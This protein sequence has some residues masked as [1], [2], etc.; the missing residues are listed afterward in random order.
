[1]LIL[2]ACGGGGN[3][4]TLATLE[5][6]TTPPT[7]GG[8]ST[9]TSIPEGTY[10]PT[11]VIDG[12]ISG[13]N[14][15][16]DMNYNFQQDNWEPSAY[17]DV[18]GEYYYFDSNDF[19]HIDNYDE[20]CLLQRPRIAE[21]PVGATD[22]IRGVVNEAYELYF[23]PY[24]N[25][26]TSAEGVDAGNVTPFTTFLI[27][28][29]SVMFRNVSITEENACSNESRDY[30]YSFMIKVQDALN[31]LENRFGL[32]TESFYDDFIASGDTEKQAIAERLVDFLQTAYKAMYAIEEEYNISTYS[33]L[34]YDLFNRILNGEEINDISFN[35]ISITRGTTEEI[36]EGE[37][38][39]VHDVYRVMDIYVNSSGQYYDIESGTI[40]EPT[41]D[42]L[43]IYGKFHVFS[44]INDV[45]LTIGKAKLIPNPF[46]DITEKRML[47]ENQHANIL[48][49]TV[50]GISDLNA[51]FGQSL[52]SNIKH[53]NAFQITSFCSGPWQLSCWAELVKT[54]E[55]ETELFNQ[56]SH[57]IEI[58]DQYESLCI[59]AN[60]RHALTANFLIKEI[61]NE[62]K[63]TLIYISPVIFPFDLSEFEFLDFSYEE[64]Q[65][66]NDL[67]E[68]N[69]LNRQ[70]M[71]L[72]ASTNEFD[73]RVNEKHVFMITNKLEN[74]VDMFVNY[75]VEGHE[76]YI[77]TEMIL[78]IEN[79]C[80]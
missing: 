64:I 25:F 46:D 67:I 39:L 60:S 21:V 78:K 30:A 9:S 49:S 14:V 8:G 72:I 41:M 45:S 22:S 19:T 2:S 24:R 6:Q 23:V 53:D 56:L 44:I 69:Y 80:N 13:A 73:N 58:F 76:N 47:S 66:F 3:V 15:F 43:K 18:Q 10:A 29:I 63:I 54:K 79:S 75:G 31:E 26:Q 34:D 51:L 50:E 12:Y 48:L 52:L 40:Y 36:V 35:I 16:F 5:T 65:Q 70:N 42:N 55:Y 77:P 38:W 27:D 71:R 59:F 20:S 68:N 4:A 32:D 7:S 62:V 1:M 28:M 37:E 17:E 61:R 57:F 11:R 33:N 74:N